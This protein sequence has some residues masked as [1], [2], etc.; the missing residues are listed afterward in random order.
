MSFDSWASR[1]LLT[2][3]KLRQVEGKPRQVEPDWCV[4]PTVAGGSDRL[5]IEHQG[6]VVVV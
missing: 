4:Q 3:G 5:G 2:T 6:G 1:A